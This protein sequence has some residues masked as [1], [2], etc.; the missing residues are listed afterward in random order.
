MSRRLRVALASP[1]PPARSGIA[2]YTR[3][4]LPHLLRHADVAVFSDTP[5]PAPVPGGVAV[6]SLR[7]LPAALREG[8]CDVAFYQLGN[9][10]PFHAGIYRQLLARPGVVLL[11]EHVLH[12]LVRD[13]TLARGDA[14]GF[15]AAMRHAAGA[16]GEREARRSLADGVPVDPWAYPLFEAAVDASRAVVV[17]NAASRDRILASR[18]AADVT[19]VPQLHE[20]AVRPAGAEDA[21]AARA[22][23][24]LP[25]DAFL[26]GAFGLVTPE[27]RMEPT[28]AAF[29]R[30]RGVVPSARLLVVG[31]VSPACDLGA[32]LADGRGAAVDVRGRVGFDDLLRL[33]TAVDVA[34]N[35]RWPTAGET[36]ATLIR[37]LGL[38]KAVV[39]SNAG[40]AAEVPDGCCAKVDVDWA[41]EETLFATLRLLAREPGLRAAMGEQARRHVLAAHDPERVAAAIVAVL[42]RAAARSTT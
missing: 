14:E 16:E 31:E 4:L 2:D 41:E 18:P 25:A 15:A 27:K 13:L 17:H 38:G 33:M 28:L 3:E 34:V 32:L 35:L 29:A 5:H 21:A 24:G 39:V 7:R 1:L 37:L 40:A 10:A 26:V 30:L 8:R 36:S 11:H 12:H 19:V 22:A 6:D 42:E 20:P 9:S 23:L